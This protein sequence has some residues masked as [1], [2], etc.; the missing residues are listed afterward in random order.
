LLT[1]LAMM[2]RALKLAGRGWGRVHPNPLV[3]AVVAQG[4]NVIAEGWHA[5][6]GGLHAERAALDGAGPAAR[7]ATLYTTL[8]PCA[9][10]GKQPPCVDAIVAA[11]IARVVVAIADPNPLAGGGVARLREAGVAV[12]VGVLATEA[13]RQNF[14]FLHHFGPSARPFVAIKLA[15]SLD[16]MVADASGA[17]RWVSGPEARTWVH[18]LR[19]GFG[20]VAVGGKTAV[21]DDARLTVRGALQ[22]R[23]PPV[24]VVFDRDG[25]MTPAHGI[26]A[27]V[28]DALVVLVVGSQVTAERRAGLARAGAQVIVADHLDVALA[29][30][31]VAGVD[32]L[33]VEGGGRLAGALLREKL[34][35][36]IYQVQCPVWLGR[37]LSAWDGLGDVAIATAQR[38]QVIERQSLGDDTLI[39]M[40]P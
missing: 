32:A 5:E 16:G 22:P 17:S 29:A 28:S 38:W 27:A 13:A 36:R 4:H 31:S 35:D 23:V 14:R 15:V 1:D 21:Q 24:R 19:A 8:E 37:G 9:H 7:G 25:R 6:F 39:V 34:V 30:L 26:F 33:L 20:G 18:A 3:G 10:L 40:E 12:D 2:Q 11:G